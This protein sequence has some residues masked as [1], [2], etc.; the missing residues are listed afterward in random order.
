M[1]PPLVKGFHLGGSQ[2]L[3]ARQGQGPVR[4]IFR[5]GGDSVLHLADQADGFVRSH[6]IVLVAGHPN[7]QVAGVRIFDHIESK[8]IA[9]SHSRVGE[10]TNARFTLRGLQRRDMLGLSVEHKDLI[11]GAH[12]TVTSKDCDLLFGERDKNWAVSDRYFW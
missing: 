3:L 12:G 5:N 8:F 9:P 10:V 1:R 7:G 4:V 11:Q 6:T 2:F